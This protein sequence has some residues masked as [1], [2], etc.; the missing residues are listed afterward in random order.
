MYHFSYSEVYFTDNHS[1]KYSRVIIST[2]CTNGTKIVKFFKAGF[3][4]VE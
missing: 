1:D 3:H 4:Y 2:K